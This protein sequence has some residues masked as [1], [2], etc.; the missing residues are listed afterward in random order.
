MPAAPLLPAE[1]PIRILIAR[2]HRRAPTHFIALHEH[3]FYQLEVL[4]RGAVRVL[5]EGKAR[6][7]TAGRAAFFGPF[8]AHGETP[9][10]HADTVDNI[11]IKFEAHA[12]W[13][14]YLRF[15]PVLRFHH[16][17]PLA[18]LTRAWMS[19]RA[20]DQMKAQLDLARLLLDLCDDPRYPRPPRAAAAR[21]DAPAWLA[22]TLDH[23]H[24][25]LAE[26]LR[27]AALAREAHLSADHFTRRFRRSMGLS[28]AAYLRRVKCERAKEGLARGLTCKET[29][30]SLGFRS[31]AYFSRSFKQ[32]AG[33][34]PTRWRDALHEPP[35]TRPLAGKGA[36][37]G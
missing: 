16:I 17:R 7:L 32:V 30:L 11:H 24:R 8:H 2:I 15:A 9:D 28:P 13:A 33:L 1:M 22:A 34:S 36:P 5:C 29:A 10:P 25:H 14:P 12:S 37:P 19:E 18:A 31:L 35:P 4:T 20:T 6:R 3:P 27:V 26:D 21:T 23:I